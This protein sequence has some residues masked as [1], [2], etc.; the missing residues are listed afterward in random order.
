MK[1]KALFFLIFYVAC[2]TSKTIT[3]SRTVQDSDNDNQHQTENVVK[4]SEVPQHE[5]ANTTLP[6]DEDRL[7][8]DLQEEDLKNPMLLKGAIQANKDYPHWFDY[9][10]GEPH[11]LCTAGDPEDFLYRGRLNS[12]GTRS[13]D[14]DQI[15]DILKETGANG[16][17]MQ[18]IRSHGGDGDNTNNP[19]VG[20]DPNQGLSDVVLN[21]WESWFEKMDQAGIVIYLFIYDDSSCIW[22]CNRSNDVD[23]PAQEIQF[24]E[25][26]VKRFSRFDHLVWIIAEE[27]EERFNFQRMDQLAMHIKKN[28]VK[29]HPV[30]LHQLPS[31]RFH[32][33]DSSYIDQFSIQYRGSSPDHYHQVLAQMH[34]S[35]YGSYNLN[36]SEPSTGTVGTGES[37]RHMIWASAMAGSYVM[38]IDWD[39]VS[40]PKK[41]L[42]ECGYLVQFMEPTML[43][44]MRPHDELAEGS[45]QF[46]MGDLDQMN[47]I[48]YSRQRGST[49]ALKQSVQGPYLLRW[50]DTI[51]GEILEEE[52]DFGTGTSS[53]NVPN[54][55]SSEIA[56]YM[57]KRFD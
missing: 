24:V 57:E 45:T 46:V 23:P 35:A 44:P 47:F 38:P 33:A 7:P 22:G 55:F 18:I 15:I 39:I 16:I 42:K 43:L 54:H 3:N 25:S 50:L 28:D 10:N 56:L 31:D 11:F 17:Y 5:Q 21:Q 37:A 53:F 14:Q 8:P 32:G 4:Q 40:T 12:D 19:F 6:D 48:L 34:Q 20:F 27:Y 2:G 41:R 9:G 36:L 52:L 29:N 49:L 26:I 13:G 51:S 1:I 30:A